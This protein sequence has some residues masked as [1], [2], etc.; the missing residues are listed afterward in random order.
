MPDL[1]FGLTW[2]QIQGM[3]QGHNSRSKINLNVLGDYGADPMGDGTFKMVPSGDIVSYEERN[4][5]LS[6]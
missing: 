1:I 5:R 3:Q 4:R 6:K 2:D